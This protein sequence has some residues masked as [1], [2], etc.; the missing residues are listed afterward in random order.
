[1]KLW[2]TPKQKWIS[3]LIMLHRRC[4]LL[5]WTSWP[6][7]TSTI[8]NHEGILWLQLLSCDLNYISVLL[9]MDLS[10][11]TNRIF[12]F[13][14][15]NGEFLYIFQWLAW[16]GNCDLIYVNGLSALCVYMLYCNLF[17]TFPGKKKTKTDLCWDQWSPWQP[18]ISPHLVGFREMVW[19]EVRL[20]SDTQ[21]ME[22]NT[23]S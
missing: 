8:T 21:W 23:M 11:K 17:G 16:C 18:K 13:Q 15:T 4:P 22:V 9:W 19:N 12:F 2:N 14:T 1:M 3:S 5:H 6:I 10:T 20:R 7:I